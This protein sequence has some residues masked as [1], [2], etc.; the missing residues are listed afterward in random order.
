MRWLLLGSAQ[1]LLIE[2]VGRCASIKLLLAAVDN[3][4]PSNIKSK[5]M[6]CE[7]SLGSLPTVS[8]RASVKQGRVDRV[9]LRDETDL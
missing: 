3:N 6:A 2:P 4:A 1:L 7:S 9:A 5:C 8:E